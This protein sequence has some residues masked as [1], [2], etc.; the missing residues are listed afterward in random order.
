VPYDFGALWVTYN[1]DQVPD[2]DIRDFD[3]FMNPAYAGQVSIPADSDDAFSLA[4]L[5]TGV[6]DMN[7]VTEQDIEAA[8]AWLEEVHH[9]LASY[10]DDE[11]VLLDELVEGEI[12]VT[13]AWNGIGSWANEYEGAIRHAMGPDTGSALWTCGFVKIAS[14]HASDDRLYDYINAVLADNSAPLMLDW[15]LGFANETVMAS[16]DYEDMT[17]ELGLSKPVGAVLNQSSVPPELHDRL[18]TEFERISGLSM[19][20]H[21]MTD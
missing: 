20:K 4:F 15:G 6:T 18:R 9:N 12:L 11:D 3:I 2:A 10:W 8:V 1:S 16:E 17:T 13:W 14:D 7:L 5:A 21:A 19:D